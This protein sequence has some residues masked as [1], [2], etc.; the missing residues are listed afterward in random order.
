MMEIRRTSGLTG[1]T[2]TRKL[3]VTPDQLNNWKAGM[4]IQDA[5]PTLSVSDREFI[6]TGITQK[7]WDTHFQK[8]WD[9][10]FGDAS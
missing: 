7:E 4:H 2:R 10:N 1:K 8:E 5:M 6:Q 3:D 9:T